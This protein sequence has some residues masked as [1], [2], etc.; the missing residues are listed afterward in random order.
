MDS[1]SLGTATVASL[2][3]RREDSKVRVSAWSIV[4]K[5]N[6]WS[7]GNYLHLLAHFKW[8]PHTLCWW[9]THVLLAER[10]FDEVG[11]AIGPRAPAKKGTPSVS[12]NEKCNTILLLCTA[13]LSVCG[14]H[15][16]EKNLE[17]M[18]KFPKIHPKEFPSLII[19]AQ[20]SAYR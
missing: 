6:R 17:K 9:I 15:L 8:S 14:L 12:I 11:Q 2:W 19:T 1:A 13:A 18:E 4:L 5:P 3:L 20:W 10:C 16:G 7:R